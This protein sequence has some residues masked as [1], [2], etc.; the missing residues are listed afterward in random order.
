M[1]PPVGQ[2]QGG[3]V[4]GARSRSGGPSR[5]RRSR[6]PELDL[7]LLG[8][9]RAGVDSVGAAT[10][11]PTSTIEPSGSRTVLAWP[12]PFR[13]SAG[14][15]KTAGL[16]ASKSS[17]RRAEGGR[18]SSVDPPM[19]ISFAAPPGP[20][21]SGTEVPKAR[22]ARSSDVPP[23]EN[24]SA[25]CDEPGVRC[26]GPAMIV[27]PEASDNM[28]GKSPPIGFCPALAVAV[29]IEFIDP[30]AGVVRR[31][32]QLDLVV[33]LGAEQDPGLV[34]PADDRDAAVGHAHPRRVP[35]AV[36]HLGL[37][38]PGLR[39]RVER[40]DL[41]EALPCR[42]GGCSELQ[43]AAEDDQLGRPR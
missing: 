32:E 21:G 1:H 12:R 20:V 35:A 10:P 16:F 34:Q 11:P 14:C 23:Q 29:P 24:G 22:V 9:R 33:G 26:P 38:E 15:Q 25:V 36:A 8:R 40:E 17:V 39:P 7:A 18:L 28:C 5:H 31:R 6:V 41:V 42:R 37:L 19:A 43:V 3:R 13:M 2:Q 27:R 4:V 30:A